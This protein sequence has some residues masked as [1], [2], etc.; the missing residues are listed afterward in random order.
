MCHFS[1]AGQETEFLI[2]ITL[3][4]NNHIWVVVTTLD[5]LVVYL[6]Y[7]LL[8]TINIQAQNKILIYSQ[9]SKTEV[10]L[11]KIILLT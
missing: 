9:S 3:D 1:C 4:L 5:T 7:L 11:S 8:Y 2:L 10:Y 6:L